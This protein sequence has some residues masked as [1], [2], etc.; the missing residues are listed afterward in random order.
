MKISIITVCYNSFS[1][2]GRTFE[3]VAQQVYPNI[4][5]IVI[6]GGSTD[7]TLELIK[8]N[9]HIINKWIS[10]PD[11]GLYDAMNKGIKIS[12]GDYIGIINADDIFY[13]ENVISNIVSFFE[14]NPVDANIANIIQYRDD[15]KIVRRYN[16]SNW[17]P[18]KLKIGFMPPHPSIFIKK[19][20]YDKLGGYKLNFE[21]GADFELITRFFLKNS[22]SW[23]YLDIITH[24]MLVG[25]LSSSGLKSYNKITKEIM[26]ALRMNSIV[27]SG[28]IIRLRVVWKIF[29]LMKR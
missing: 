6:D 11:D 9:K 26:K 29:E 4:E 7:G 28:F 5:Y 19:S 27:Y 25:G 10:E 23:K 14:E 2:I 8:E 21:I 12:T 16:S 1:T 3:S 22:I 17:S 24:K 20:I 18:T 15:G 13:D